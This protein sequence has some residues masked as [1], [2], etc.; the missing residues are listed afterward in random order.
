[1][2]P[3]PPRGLAQM[4]EGTSMAPLAAASPLRP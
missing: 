3:A 1:M 2:D 4:P